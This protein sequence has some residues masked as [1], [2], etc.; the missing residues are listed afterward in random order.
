[1]TDN[2]HLF[3]EVP[4]IVEKIP[5]LQNA[6]YHYFS[7]TTL[8]SIL[9]Q[10]GF[11]VTHRQTIQRN[12]YLL[13]LAKYTGITQVAAKSSGEFERVMKVVA[14]GRRGMYKAVI[15]ERLPFPLRLMLSKILGR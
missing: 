2:G 10:A 1:L 5:S 15:A 3:V 4:G 13:V 8:D 11:E 12:G 7:E 9:G 14:N 6:H